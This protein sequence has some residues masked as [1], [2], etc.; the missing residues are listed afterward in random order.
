MPTPK[1]PVNPIVWNHGDKDVD[2]TE[3]PYADW[4]GGSPWAAAT[5]REIEVQATAEAEDTSRDLGSVEVHSS[6]GS[7]SHDTSAKPYTQPVD[8]PLNDETE[9]RPPVMTHEMQHVVQEAVLD[10]E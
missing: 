4:P 3:N 8:N 6:S 9:K 5:L 10:Q 7:D 2:K 1:K